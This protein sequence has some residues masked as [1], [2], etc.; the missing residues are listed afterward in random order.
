MLEKLFN[1]KSLSGRQ[2]ELKKLGKVLKFKEGIRKTVR[3][4]KK[5]EKIIFLKIDFSILKIKKNII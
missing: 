5:S 2:I 3:M 4:A 1:L